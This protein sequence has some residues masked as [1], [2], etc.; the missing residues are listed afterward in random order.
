M[1]EH[2]SVAYCTPAVFKGG[3]NI[4]LVMELL[5]NRDV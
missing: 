5:K 4:A 2:G 1:H 3:E